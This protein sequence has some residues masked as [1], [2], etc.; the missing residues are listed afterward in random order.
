MD[1]LVTI[2]A[3]VV[4]FKVLAWMFDKVL[5]PFLLAIPIGIVIYPFVLLWQ[6]SPVLFVILVVVV[7]ALVA[8]PAWNAY[9]EN[10]EIKAQAKAI[11]WRRMME[12][13]QETVREL[14]SKGIQFK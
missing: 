6:F 2:L 5:G 10:R 14:E 3:I 8:K 13:H 12:K 9:K 7:P 11:A 4:L 1:F